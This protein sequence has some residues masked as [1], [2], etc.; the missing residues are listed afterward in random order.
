MFNLQETPIVLATREMNKPKTRIIDR[1]GH[2]IKLLEATAEVVAMCGLSRTTISRIQEE[3]GLSRGMI[4]LHFK[5]KDNLILEL[6]KYLDEQYQRNWEEAIAAVSNQPAVRLR[7][8]FKAEFDHN[9]LTKRNSAVWFS[10]RSE[11]KSNSKLIQYVE[12]RDEFLNKEL[13]SCCRELSREGGYPVK[14]KLAVMAFTSLMEGLETD[15]ELHPED[16]NR[17]TA[18]EVC[19]AVAKGFFP[20]HF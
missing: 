3:S 20:K 18:V 8:I 2:R 5:S 1:E 4:N 12:S 19:L 17:K 11:C 15:F 6:A 14:P 7:A 10:L 9:I 16:F 13:F